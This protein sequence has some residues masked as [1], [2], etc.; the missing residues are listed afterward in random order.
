[1]TIGCIADL[2]SAVRM[3]ASV[4]D[5]YFVV[6]SLAL[7]VGCYFLAKMQQQKS[8]AGFRDLCHTASHLFV[9][10]GHLVLMRSLGDVTVVRNQ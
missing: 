3:S 10:G 2:Y 4:V 9:T 5:T 7:A 1:M 6:L 8:T